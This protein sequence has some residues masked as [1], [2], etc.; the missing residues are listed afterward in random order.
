MSTELSKLLTLLFVLC[1]D[2]AKGSAALETAVL[3]AM[4]K[5]SLDANGSKVEAAGWENGSENAGTAATGAGAAVSSKGSKIAAN[6]E[7]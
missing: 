4:G 5:L 1:V 2:T 3:G 7:E 6:E